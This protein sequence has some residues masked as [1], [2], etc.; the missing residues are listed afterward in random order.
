MKSM[1][2]ALAVLVVVIIGLSIIVIEKNEQRE[3]TINSTYSSPERL[4]IEMERIVDAAIKRH[5][6]YRLRTDERLRHNPDRAIECARLWLSYQDRE[7]SKD[8]SR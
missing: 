8:S 3:L 4:E 5:C 7:A 1:L 2:I 6:A